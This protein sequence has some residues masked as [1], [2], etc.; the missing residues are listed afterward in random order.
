[1][2]QFKPGLKDSPPVLPVSWTDSSNNFKIYWNMATEHWTNFM[3]K[4]ND[5]CDGNGK[6]RPPESEVENQICAQLPRWACLG[7]NE[8]PSFPASIGTAPRSGGCCGRGR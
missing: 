8:E 4:I 5:Y 6:G 2:L 7:E 3:Q 1:M